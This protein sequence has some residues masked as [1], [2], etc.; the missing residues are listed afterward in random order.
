MTGQASEG[1]NLCE[2]ENKY[3]HA[4]VHKGICGN[5]YVCLHIVIL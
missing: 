2:R 1:I 3:G 4:C 5:L